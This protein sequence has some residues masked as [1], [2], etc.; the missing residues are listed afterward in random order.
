MVTIVFDGVDNPPHYEAE[1]RRLCFQAA[2]KALII[3]GSV[4]SGLPLNIRAY[5]N[6]EVVHK[7]VAEHFVS[8]DNWLQR[9]A[10]HLDHE[11]NNFS[12]NLWSPRRR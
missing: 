4:N 6:H 10:I 5:E 3:K 7:L 11:L 1:L 2:A 8:H 9:L 12:Q